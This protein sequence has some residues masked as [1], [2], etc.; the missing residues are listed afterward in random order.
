MAEQA[1]DPEATEREAE[2]GDDLGAYH[3]DALADE[4]GMG[5]VFRARHRKLGRTVAIKVLRRKYAARPDALARF[6]QEARAVNVI[7]HPNM[8]EITDF[9]EAPGATSYYVMEW[10]DGVSLATHL[11]RQGA[12]AVEEVVN[13]ATQVASALDVAH[14][15]GFVHRD[16]TPG[17]LFLVRRE[18]RTL[19]KVLDFGVA[20][21]DGAD[22]GK[23][24]GTPAY[25][26]PEC[27]G[28]RGVDARSDIYSLGVI[29]YQALS[30]ALPFEGETMAELA[31]KHLTVRP[32]PL[33]SRVPPAV[34]LLVARCLEKRPALRF[35]TMAEL[36]EALAGL[37]L[38]GTER[39]WSR[40]RRWLLA[41]AG[42]LA[43]AAVIGVAFGGRSPAPPSVLPLPATSALLASPP[44]FVPS[45][46]EESDVGGERIEVAVS[47]LPPGAE[48]FKGVAVMGTTPCTVRL[49][50]GETTL[51][52]RR[53]G[54]RPAARTVDAQPGRSV[55]VQ[56]DPVAPRRPIRAPA[57]PARNATIDPF[58]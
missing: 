22:D 58:R 8:V 17:N 9:F 3:L 15:V 36:E 23:V 41:A 32:R 51:V 20:I 45:L 54:F 33:S 5:R 55:V 18:G 37:P 43:A 46:P 40:P 42:P 28:S 44:A 16:V 31:M 24:V 4:G 49:P 26:S 30:G 14:R 12:L 39:G 56:L 48:V 57:A 53:Q 11:D 52:L 7:R 47:S 34:A 25:F 1:S 21:L 29:L 10:L 38:Q 6:F 13:I 50:R 27:A 35:Q 2:A 19:V